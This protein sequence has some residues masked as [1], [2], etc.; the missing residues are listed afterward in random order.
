MTPI[1]AAPPALSRV[2][3]AAVVA[4]WLWLA[5]PALLWLGPALGS[6][7]R[8]VHLAV[9]AALVALG[10]RRARTPAAAAIAAP[11]A[12]APPPLAPLALLLGGACAL[13]LC[14]GPAHGAPHVVVALLACLGACALAPLLFPSLTRGPFWLYALLSLCLVPSQFHLDALFGFRLR[15]WTA[16]LIARQL[17]LFGVPVQSAASLLVL[18]TGAVHID[19]P[20]SGLRSLWTGLLF[21]L[22]LSALRRARPA[23]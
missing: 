23:R 10:L 8:R 14:L 11:P 4:A 3:T 16:E 6:P 15:L 17:P 12:Q 2:A 7:D 22:L 18:E 19:L 20:C 5:W 13:G 21:F 9:I 1:H